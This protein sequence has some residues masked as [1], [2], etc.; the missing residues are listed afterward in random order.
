MVRYLIV[1][2]FLAFIST[3]ALADTLKSEQ[4]AK[5]LS[6]EIIT[7]FSKEDLGDVINLMEPYT[8]I[9]GEELKGSLLQSKALRDQHINRYGKS[10][11][12][13]FIGERKAGDSLLKLVYIEKTEKHVFPWTF[14]F[15]RASTGWTLNSFSWDDQVD[16]AFRL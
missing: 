2:F 14:F 16:N 12:Y 8:A 15:Y 3:Q 1:I 6:E 7:L 9:Q 4:D 13:E 11:G 5:K 10:I